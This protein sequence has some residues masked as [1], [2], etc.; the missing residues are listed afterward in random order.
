MK[1]ALQG[2]TKQ[3][4]LTHNSTSKTE[5]KR[6]YRT[7]GIIRRALAVLYDQLV[8]T[9]GVNYKP[10]EWLVNTR[11]KHVRYTVMIKLWLR[12]I[13]IVAWKIITSDRVLPKLFQKVVIVILWCSASHTIDITTGKKL[14]NDICIQ[15]CT[16]AWL[17]TLI[18]K[19]TEFLQATISYFVRRLCAM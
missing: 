1:R 11:V 17:R 8:R 14:L 12:M 16:L 13:P 3:N 7:P 15:R 18:F 9:N 10:Y 6:G 4:K 2:V 19:R 5:Q